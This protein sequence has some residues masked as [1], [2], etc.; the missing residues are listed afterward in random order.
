MRKKYAGNMCSWL[1][2]KKRRLQF[3]AASLYGITLL[4]R[5]RSLP[6]QY[7]CQMSLTHHYMFAHI[8]IACFLLN[9]VDQERC[10]SSLAIHLGEAF[11]WLRVRSSTSS[12]DVLLESSTQVN[13]LHLLVFYS[14][15]AA[16]LVGPRISPRHH[17]SPHLILR[18]DLLPLPSMNGLDLIHL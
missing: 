2:L 1:S 3:C 13:Y 17:L 16:C 8:I 14:K 9:S 15:S 12:A 18:T 4:T 10:R 6:T 7:G 5:S 11:C